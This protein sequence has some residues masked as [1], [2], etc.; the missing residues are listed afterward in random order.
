MEFLSDSFSVCTIRARCP[1][2][3]ER[4]R[5]CLSRS[6]TKAR[7]QN[8]RV[9]ETGDVVQ[10]RSRSEAI[11]V[12]DAFVMGTRI[13]LAKHESFGEGIPDTVFCLREPSEGADSRDNS[14]YGRGHSEF[15][16]KSG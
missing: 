13:H 14:E 9:T 5:V 7:I 16:F 11:A 4:D 10:A 15:I 1:L 6:S 12:P 2:L 3:E 8:S